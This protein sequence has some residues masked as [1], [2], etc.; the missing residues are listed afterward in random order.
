MDGYFRRLASRALGLEPSVQ[1]PMPSLFG[2]AE[3]WVDPGDTAPLYTW[4]SPSGE[5]ALED[6][7]RHTSPGSPD[8]SGARQPIVRAAPLQVQDQG[9]DDTDHWGE[10]FSPDPTF[11]PTP[12]RATPP[13]SPRRVAGIGA[14]PEPTL[15][16]RDL[17]DQDDGSARQD[18][19][20]SP[21]ANV[22]MPYTPA[23]A[24][25]TWQVR[26]HQRAERRLMADGGPEGD[27]DGVGS[28]PSPSPPGD[29]PAGRKHHRRPSAPTSPLPVEDHPPLRSEPHSAAMPRSGVATRARSI[30]TAAPAA[31]PIATPTVEVT[32]GRIE[33]RSVAAPNPVP[34]PARRPEAR[35]ALSLDDYLRARRESKA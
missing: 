21:A 10:E 27:L 16:D 22:A 32:I 34:A 24:P 20:G 1:P 19:T 5:A 35:P 11:A 13:S 33:V 9:E 31:E 12:T 4:P 6:E 18:S 28:E 29:M 14:T 2:R 3:V 7:A 15:P 23:S 26:P 25:H 17:A 8:S 30:P